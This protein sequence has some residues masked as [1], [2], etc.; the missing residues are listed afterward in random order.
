M[1]AFA[2]AKREATFTR[3]NKDELMEVTVSDTLSY[4]AHAF[5]SNNR[6]DPRLDADGK[7]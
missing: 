4:L 3:R 2:Q 5:S 6:P 1:S 7:T